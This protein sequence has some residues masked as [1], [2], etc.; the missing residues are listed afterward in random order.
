MKNTLSEL[1]QKR[2]E[3]RRDILRFCHDVLYWR[4]SKGVE[5]W[6]PYRDQAQAMQAAVASDRHNLPQ[7]KITAF[8]WPKRS[9]KSVASAAILAHSLVTGTEAHSV[10]C[11]N[12]REQASTVTF[13]AL[14]NFIRHSPV[15]QALVPEGDRLKNTISCPTWGNWVRALPANVATVQG[16]SVTAWAVFDDAHSAPLDVLDMVQSQTE[17][18]TARVLVPSMMGSVKGYVHRL[19]ETSQRPGSAHICF[20]WWHGADANKNP[21]VPAAWLNQRRSE[22][23]PSVYRV[24]HENEAGEGADSLFTVEQL[25]ACRENWLPPTTA[26]EWEALCRQQWGRW[27]DQVRLG[28]GLDR[29]LGRGDETVFAVVARYQDKAGVEHYAMVRCEAIRGSDEASILSAAEQ[30]RE[31]F[32]RMHR[33][34][35]E[36]YQMADVAPKWG[37]AL[38]CRAELESAS[39]QA[40]AAAFNSLWQLVNEQRFHYPTGFERLHEELSAFQIYDTGSHIPAFSGG[41]GKAVD[42]HVYAGVWALVAAQQVQRNAGVRFL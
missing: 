33:A 36:V 30:V 27:P 35:A 11:S 13:E 20:I 18:P 32:G 21:Y 28:A 15:L 37:K 7:H 42:D 40:Q 19:Y 14:I 38:G 17:M 16:V 24:F 26:A 10:V 25:E 12:S 39:R 34:T 4:T 41:S 5:K 9:G 23:P 2:E 22:L 3:W 6:A 8:C 31:V 1:Q 29:S